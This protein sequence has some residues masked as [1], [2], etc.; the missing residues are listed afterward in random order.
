MARPKPAWRRVLTG[1]YLRWRALTLAVTAL[2]PLGRWLAFF[3]RAVGLI[4]GADR[5]LADETRPVPPEEIAP[6][7][8]FLA[9]C[10]GHDSRA[11]EVD[12]PH[13]VPHGVVTG[14][15]TA[16]Y[17]RP[18]LDLGTG[19]ILLPDRGATVLARG[20]IVNRNAATARPGRRPVPLQGRAWAPPATHNYF[21]LLL[22]NGLQ[23]VD[24]LDSG[25]EADAP[26]TIVKPPDRGA[27]ESALWRGIA[28]LYP[29]VAIRHFHGAKLVE[30]DEAVAH[31]PADNYWE[32]PPVTRAQA[33]RLA[34]AFDA[35]HG[36][37]ASAPGP[38]RL[39]LSRA[40]AKLREPFN[41]AALEQALAERGFAPLVATDDNHAEQIARFRAAR[42][43]WACTAPG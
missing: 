23:A 40:G 22:E 12:L 4:E 43:S 15:R 13:G 24:L 18:W 1:R 16:L 27:V 7:M 3:P 41:A 36:A 34:A 14:R 35:V 26:L 6:D 38:D 42:T 21:H 8:D 20:A 33:D 28:A 30:P 31:F 10:A 5:V 32:W 2:P 25:L 17:R 37:A 19:A 9:L 39:Y 11:S 29:S